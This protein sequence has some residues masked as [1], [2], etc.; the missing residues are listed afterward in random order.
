MG[1]NGELVSVFEENNLNNDLS[2]FARPMNF[3]NNT[4]KDSK[5]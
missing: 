3:N 4:I 1:E 5:K 2:E